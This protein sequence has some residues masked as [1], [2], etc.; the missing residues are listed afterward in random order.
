MASAWLKRYR[1]ASFRNIAFYIKGHSVTGGRRLAEHVFPLVDEP[2]YED[3]GRK[4]KKFTIDAYVVADDYFGWR[5]NL[6]RA[7]DA[8]GPGKLV[9]PYRGVM[10]VY[11]AEWTLS[12]VTEEGRMARFAITFSPESSE[13]LTVE[14]IYSKVTVIA[15]KK[16]LLETIHDA[17]VSSYSTASLQVNKLN[18]L[19]ETLDAIDSVL[20]DTKLLMKPY[21][22]FQQILSNAE[23]KTIAIAA[24]ASIIVSS[25]TDTIDFGTDTEQDVSVTASTALQ[26]FS[27]MV[28]SSSRVSAKTDM[29]QE[30]QIIS[31]QR[32]LSVASAFTLI[33]EIPFESA[34]DAQNSIDSLLSV[35]EEVLEDSNTTDD[36]FTQF[37]DLRTYVYQILV[38]EIMNLRKTKTI[39]LIETTPALVVS[40][41]LYGDVDH[42]DEIQRRNRIG[43]PGFIPG[44]ISLRVLTDV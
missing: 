24:D 5:D 36:E 9:H 42:A 40:N 19:V 7:L 14:N 1:Q 30:E 6:E 26:M 25:M 15:K 41:T 17:F 3:L 35:L 28:V 18:K 13:V 39:T 8:E 34:D 23:G 22:E 32:K 4:A 38:D 27:A 44:G 12:E 16:S 43:H 11:V 37:V 20:E 33:I 2:Q 29:K 31:L 10:Q 21:S